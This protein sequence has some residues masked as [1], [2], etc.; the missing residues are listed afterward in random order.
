MSTSRVGDSEVARSD[1][2]G[3]DDYMSVCIGCRHIWTAASQIPSTV[4]QHLAQTYNSYIDL[5]EGTC[6]LHV[7]GVSSSRSSYSLL[8]WDS[9]SLFDSKLGLR[10]KMVKTALKID[11][12]QVLRR[13]NV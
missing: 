2:L 10:L 9:E 1:T 7:T 3:R 6:K 13:L 12:C 5:S 8:T 11:T 4:F